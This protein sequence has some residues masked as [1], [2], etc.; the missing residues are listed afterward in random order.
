MSYVKK[1][2]ASGIEQI[3]KLQAR[4]N[5]KRK[6]GRFFFLCFIS[7]GLIGGFKSILVSNTNVDGEQTEYST[8]SSFATNYISRYFSY[9][10]IDKKWIVENTASNVDILDADEE[11][12]IT[13]DN[14]EISSVSKKDESFDIVVYYDLNQIRRYSSL[15]IVYENGQF[16]VIS[17]VLVLNVEDKLLYERIIEFD[18]GEPVSSED[19]ETVKNILS[20]FFAAV[21]KDAMNATNESLI[22]YNKKVLVGEKTLFDI[23]SIEITS[24]Y[25]IENKTTSCIFSIEQ[26]IFENSTI[27]KE[28]L[29]NIN[30]TNNKILKLEGK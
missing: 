13:V 17:G 10:D 12:V 29:V 2:K 3:Y 11:S 27:N 22:F 28:Y 8:V 23:D 16:Y 21:N 25:K 18:V 19:S 14:V 24:C 1:N 5:R 9:L 26:K 20:S 7:L 6:I 15:E 30:L 4:Y